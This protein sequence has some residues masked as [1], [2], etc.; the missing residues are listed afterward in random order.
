MKRDL[1]DITM[2]LD[3]S[4]SMMVC[5]ENTE[6]GVNHFIEENKKQEGECLFTLVHFD[7]EYEFVHRG[8]PIQDVLAYGLHPR[9]CTA[10]LDAVGKAIVDTGI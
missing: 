6:G 1:C 8:K 4:G 7:T 5:K 10:L 3:R 9:G 2:V